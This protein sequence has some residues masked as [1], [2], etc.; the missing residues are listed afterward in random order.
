MTES[1]FKESVDQGLNLLKSGQLREGIKQ[2]EHSLK[3]NPSSGDLYGFVNFNLPDVF[4][5]ID[6]QLYT[7][8][9]AVAET[10]L[11]DLE[12]L[13]SGIDPTFP[14]FPALADIYARIGIRYAN[15]AKGSN[16][17]FMENAILFIE[18]ARTISRV[19]DYPDYVDKLALIHGFL[20]QYHA[21]RQQWT[22]AE[23][24]LKMIIELKPQDG[25]SWWNLCS[26]YAAQSDFENAYACLVR[27]AE[28]GDSKAIARL[29][30]MR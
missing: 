30:E 14:D 26:I 12:A 6:Q 23:K 1:N 7:M 19:P 10:L 24:H 25:E 27:S 3:Q 5:I 2:L 9:D 17:V 20:A 15:L 13:T 8:P 18:K 11:I 16:A 4:N 22:Q 29:R 28:L 21:K